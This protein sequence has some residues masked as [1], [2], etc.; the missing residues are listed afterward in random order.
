MC[1]NNLQL[2]NVIQGHLREKFRIR[3]LNRFRKVDSH[4][5]NGQTTGKYRR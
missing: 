1:P 5:S 2:Q 3:R 4:E